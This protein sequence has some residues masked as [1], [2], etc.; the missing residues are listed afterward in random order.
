MITQEQLDADLSNVTA[1]QKVFETDKAAFDALQP[2]LT[3]LAEI[4]G[5]AEHI[6]AE[7]KDGFVAAIA[8]ARA[9]F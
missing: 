5:Y 6:S 2:H 7:V 9:L 1:A 3:V 4:E 8:K